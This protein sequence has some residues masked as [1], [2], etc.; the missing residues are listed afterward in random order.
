MFLAERAELE[1]QR[2]R[3]A[4]RLSSRDQPSHPDNVGMANLPLLPWLDPGASH[5]PGG[6][7]EV[8][9]TYA[10]NLVNYEL[11]IP[12]AKLIIFHFFCLL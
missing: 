4:S 8:C 9:V 3:L 11:E 2:Q 1:E 6:V 12:L 10:L 7:E 5:L